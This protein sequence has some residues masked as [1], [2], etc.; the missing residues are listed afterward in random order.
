MFR[1]GGA[2]T[3]SFSSKHSVSTFCMQP[4]AW[5]HSCDL[6]DLASA[7]RTLSFGGRDRMARVSIRGLP[8]VKPHPTKG[9]P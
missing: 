4:G 6:A 7:H 2:Y 5:G 3:I 1:G 8:L 9:R